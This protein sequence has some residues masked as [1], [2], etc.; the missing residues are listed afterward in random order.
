MMKIIAICMLMFVSNAV[1]SQL[2]KWEISLELT[3]TVSNVT[4]KEWFN[5]HAA[6]EASY[7]GFLKGGYR[8]NRRLV[9]TFGLGYLMTA[10]FRRIPFG[11]TGTGNFTEQL[12][13]HHYYVGTVGMKFNF[14][15]FFI[16]PEI[17]IAFNRAHHVVSDEYAIGNNFLDVERSRFVIESGALERRVTFPAM[18]SFGNEFDLG[19][20]KL[21]LGAKAYY[22]LNTVRQFG[23]NNGKYYGFGIMTGIKF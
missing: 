6:F 8:I 21:L 2:R 18:L 1:L 23:N 9:A 16:N 14:G 4:N 7:N 3:P 13:R 19:S 20:V 5:G 10:E 17:G 11:I 15:S 22:S 12:T